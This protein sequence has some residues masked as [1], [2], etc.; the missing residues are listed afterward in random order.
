L[1]KKLTI[2]LSSVFSVVAFIAVPVAVVII[3]LNVTNN[4][5]VL[6]ITEAEKLKITPQKHEAILVVPETPQ[7]FAT[8]CTTSD[9]MASRVEIMSVEVEELEAF[10]NYVNVKIIF[11]CRKSYDYEQEWGEQNGTAGV[12]IVVTQI[13]ENGEQVF[14]GELGRAEARINETFDFSYTA[15]FRAGEVHIIE[16]EDYYY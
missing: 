12:G 1:K 16:I 5:E 7:D 6:V 3:A 9:I 11:K 14:S 10:P 4:I 15:S 8:I 13:N 2:I